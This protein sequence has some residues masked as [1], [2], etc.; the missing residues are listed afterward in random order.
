MNTL[1]AGDDAA[2]AV[3]V[4]PR[5]TLEALEAKI[6]EGTTSYSVFGDTLTVCVIRLPSGFSLVGKSA[7][8]DPSNFNRALGEQF[9]REDAIRS[10]W[11]LEG[12]VLAE[13]LHEQRNAP[14]LPAAGTP[15]VQISLP[16][17]DT[18]IATL[19]VEHPSNMSAID[20]AKALEM[21]TAARNE[22]MGVTP[23]IMTA[24]DP[25][26]LRIGEGTPTS[27]A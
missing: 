24:G 6:A 23:Q 7:C 12:Y 10:L 21:L 20:V 22:R 3:A 15:L 1:Q 11:G 8:A 19:D 16:D 5:V 18:I 2:A 27:D 4:A 9:A 25:L 17:L 26:G 13:R 14:P